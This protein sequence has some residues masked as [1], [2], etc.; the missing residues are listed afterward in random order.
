VRNI[1]LGRR[2]TI[3]TEERRIF[4]N[5]DQHQAFMKEKYPQSEEDRSEPTYPELPLVDAFNW[6]SWSNGRTCGI[7]FQ[8]NGYYYHSFPE[9]PLISH[10]L[11][12]CGKIIQRPQ[13]AFGHYQIMWCDENG[14]FLMQLHG[15]KFSQ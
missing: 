14:K 13:G 5:E 11:E 8:L 12:K 7:S 10:V 4:S 9:Q 6:Q 1:E 15:P 3:A 2:K